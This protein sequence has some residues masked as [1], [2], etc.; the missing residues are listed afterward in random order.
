[1]PVLL[2][3]VPA[4]HEAAS[5]NSAQGGPGGAPPTA[6]ETKQALSK[7]EALR[8]IGERDA[9]LAALQPLLDSPDAG[10]AAEAS[11]Q[12]AL[13]RLELGSPKEAAGA[14]ESLLARFPRAAN[15]DR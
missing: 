6:D 8:R 13:L 2:A 7:A 4:M 14:L 11:Y 5:S 3:T 10:L 9:A 12:V 1:P 15:A